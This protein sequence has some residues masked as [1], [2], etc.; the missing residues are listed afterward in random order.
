MSP[1]MNVSRGYSV[2]GSMQTAGPL[3]WEVH[4]HSPGLHC[5]TR[6]SSTHGGPALMRV[7]TSREQ[8]EGRTSMSARACNQA[9]SS[10]GQVGLRNIFLCGPA[11]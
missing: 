8:A 4:S 5:L 2:P 7:R 11:S 6:Q 3:W 9:A 1:S 10:V